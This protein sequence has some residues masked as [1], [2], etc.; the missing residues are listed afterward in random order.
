[1]TCNAEVRTAGAPSAIRLSV[2]RNTI[3]TSTGDVAHVSLE[4]VDSAGTVVP[5]A[6]NL[7]RFSATGGSLLLVDNANLQDLEPY[8]T[9]RR[10]AFNGRGLAIL[11]AK[12]PGVLRVR[13]TADGLKPASASIQVV[14]GAL[15]PSVPSAGEK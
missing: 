13:A 14:R 12:E 10:R 1:V 7:V 11:R 3:T 5:T 6:E 4:I 15:V 8:R 2:D 9:D